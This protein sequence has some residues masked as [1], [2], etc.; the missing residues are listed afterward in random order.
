M[1]Y[2]GANQV[3]GLCSL[4]PI[5]LKCACFTAGTSVAI[6]WNARLFLLGF[7]SYRRPTGLAKAESFERDILIVTFDE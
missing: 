3:S 2:F 1:Q 6:T 7:N 5:H 4:I